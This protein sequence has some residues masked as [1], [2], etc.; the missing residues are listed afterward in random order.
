MHSSGAYPR[1]TKQIITRRLLSSNS[2]GISLA[3]GF[4]V[5]LEVIVAKG[6]FASLE[7]LVFSGSD[8][9]LVKGCAYR[10]GEAGGM[11]LLLRFCLEIL[12]FDSA[13]TCLA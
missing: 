12:T 9:T 5:H 8:I 7:R 1:Y 4:A 13:I 11:E 2:H 6:L 3:I 10:T